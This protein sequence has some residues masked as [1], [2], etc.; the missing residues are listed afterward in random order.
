MMRYVEKDSPYTG[1][2]RRRRKRSNR[3]IAKYDQRQ[4]EQHNVL[5]RPF[6][7]TAGVALIL[8]G[9]AIGWLPGPGF[10]VL[11]LQ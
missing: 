10:V 3:F 4:R 11:A 5:V 6:R 7:I 2:E 8:G 1:P 9:V